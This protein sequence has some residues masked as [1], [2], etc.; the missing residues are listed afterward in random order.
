MQG[1]YTYYPTYPSSTDVQVSD[2]CTK[3][4]AQLINFR[5][6][7]GIFARQWLF[8]AAE[9]VPA[10]LWCIAPPLPTSAI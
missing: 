10:H 6:G 7:N 2:F 9:K 5:N 4:N 8:D 3:V 1:T